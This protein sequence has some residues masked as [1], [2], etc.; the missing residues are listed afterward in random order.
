MSN[1]Y[2]VLFECPKCHQNISIRRKSRVMSLSEAEARKVFAAEQ[3]TCGGPS[4]G[5][6]GAASKTRL[7]QIVPFHWIYN[8]AS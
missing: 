2:Q 3:L 8:I 7:V 5:W 4:C 1:A 6:H